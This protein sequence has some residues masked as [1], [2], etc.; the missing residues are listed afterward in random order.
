MIVS[1]KEVLQKYED[2]IMAGGYWDLPDQPDWNRGGQYIQ[3]SMSR[4]HNRSLEQLN[5][6]NRKLA[7][8]P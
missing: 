5:E 3:E 1:S 4:S 8:L 7:Q 6:V 2:L